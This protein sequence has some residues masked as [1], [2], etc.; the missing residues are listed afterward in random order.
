MVANGLLLPRIVRPRHM[1]ETT[2]SQQTEST[3]YCC[4]RGLSSNK[5]VELKP[6]ALGAPPKQYERLREEDHHRALPGIPQC[7]TVLAPI[8]LEAQ[9]PDAPTRWRRAS[10]TRRRRSS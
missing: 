4:F 2:R 10:S 1:R 9:L 7:E 5:V 6:G 8:D 3:S